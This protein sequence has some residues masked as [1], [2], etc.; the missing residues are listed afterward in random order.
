MVF[1]VTYSLP[2]RMKQHLFINQIWIAIPRGLFGI[3][4]AWSVFGNPFQPMPLIIGG[5]ATVFLIGGMATK[6]VVDC[7][8][9]KRTGTHTLV[10][11][12]GAKKTALISFPFMFFPFTIIPIMISKGFLDAY[13]WPLFLLIFLSCIVFYFMMR[14]SES[15]TLENTHAW[16][17]MYI[18]YMIF[19]LGFS[20]LIILSNYVELPTLF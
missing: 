2:P 13:L 4:A 19:A 3:L 6:D 10:N 15:E 14:E 12:F 8:A 1:T 9:D 7:V 5:I 16:A 17:L 18:E 20:V 11:T